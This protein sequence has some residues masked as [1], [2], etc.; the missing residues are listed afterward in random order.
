MKEKLKPLQKILRPLLIIGVLVIL[1][2]RLNDIGWESVLQ[3]VPT[4]PL[5]YLISPLIFFILPVNEV[6]TYRILLGRRVEN[7][8][9][10]FSRKRVLNDSVFTYSGEFYLLARLRQIPDL[11]KDKD[12][13]FRTIL[14]NN[15]ISAL[16]SN[17]VTI[18]LVVSML[19]IGRIDVIETVYDASPIAVS[20]FGAFCV[21]LY[22][23]SII[24]FRR[25]N[26][27]TGKTF[28]ALFGLH[29]ARAL[30][31]MGLQMLQWSLGMPGELFLTWLVFLT[32]QLLLSRLPLPNLEL[33]FF[34]V[35]ISLSGLADGSEAAVIAMFGAVTATSLVI[36][37]I[38]FIS[39]SFIK[40]E[41]AT[42]QK[43][44]AE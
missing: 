10:I 22:I 14:D 1:V 40:S 23:V 38:T 2:W 43:V 12:R 13:L 25:S 30:A 29:T 44:P 39:T 3:E 33:V 34:A 36:Q 24:F 5:F 27:I 18:L 32:L 28:W 15:M 7:G 4:S 9:A 16:V 20:S 41:P 35:A 11:H 8:F 26:H 42:P 17:S 6:M 21:V 31:I 37:L 19:M